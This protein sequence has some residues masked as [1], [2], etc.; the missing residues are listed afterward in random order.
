MYLFELVAGV[1]CG[2]VT[3]S[4]WTAAVGHVSLRGSAGVAWR[5]V[6]GCRYG[7]RRG[8]RRWGGP[9]AGCRLVALD[10][11]VVWGR[12][13]SGLA[14]SGVWGLLVSRSGSSRTVSPASGNVCSGGQAGVMMALEINTSQCLGLSWRRWQMPA[15]GRCASS[16][17]LGSRLGRTATLP[18]LPSSAASR[19]RTWESRE[20][21]VRTLR[22]ARYRLRTGRR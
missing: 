6:G 14:L 20:R 3:W 10:S 13:S 12:G 19:T 7:W 5:G 4:G 17:S 21:R 15:L 9:D 2:P 16:R 18:T 11:D 1:L 8:V 22:R